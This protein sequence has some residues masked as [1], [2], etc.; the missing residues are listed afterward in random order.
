M[1]TILP[2]PGELL[3]ELCGELGLD[4]DAP[5]WGWTASQGSR[6]LGYVIVAKDEPCRI[7]ALQAEDRELADGLLR[8]ALH[9]FYEE[10]IR[11]YT[12]PT[13][14]NLLLPSRYVVMGH[15]SLEALFAPCGEGNP[16]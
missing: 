6:L 8:A 7:L 16:T 4:D 11:E 3:L 5:L 2:L 14:P 13:P 15:G 10:G 9:P 1:V 12:F